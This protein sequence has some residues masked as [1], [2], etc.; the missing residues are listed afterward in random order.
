MSIL[1]TVSLRKYLELGYNVL[2]SGQHGVG[3]TEIIKQ[4]FESA[5]L[6]WKYFSASTLDPYVDF[7]GV[8]KVI[9]RPD[10]SKILELIRPEAFQDD[11]IEAIFIDE[12]NRAPDKVL[13]AVLELIQF[14]SINGYKL[15]N[16]KVIW[17]AIN[18]EDEDDTYSVNHLDPA[19]LDRFHVYINVPFK[20]DEAYFKEKYPLTGTHFID[21]WKD[22][23]VEIRTKV[24]PRRLDYAAAAHQNNC[25][26]EDFLPAESNISK[27]RQMLKSTPFIEKLSAIKTNEA[28]QEFLSDSNNTIKMLELM[29]ASES[30]VINFFKTYGQNL[31]K[32]LLEPFLDWLRVRQENLHNVK[33]L[34]ELIEKLPNDHG[35]AQTAATINNI[36]L[37]PILNKSGTIENEF[38]QMCSSNK[39]HI[40]TK[41]SN[42]MKDIVSSAQT[43]TLEKIF[44]GPGG[45]IANK[46]TNF[47]TILRALGKIDGI[48]TTT[49]KTAIVD[50]LMEK[51]IIDVKFY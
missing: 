48:F 50:R 21:W 47:Q 15:K 19:H 35:N 29:K 2:F 7:I 42:R 12:L 39:K 41:L 31:P 9:D 10:G 36:D 8:P 28:A 3:K 32:E 33:T 22:M 49:E 11:Q 43:S 5:N 46:E 45:K 37:V 34:E 24:S 40:I 13:N 18:P 17:G 23:P 27:L 30:N 16:L 25:R 1:D 6:K 20:V 51:K 4:T 14:K 44:W 26:L 38:Q